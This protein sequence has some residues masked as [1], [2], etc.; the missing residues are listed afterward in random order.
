[1]MK[2]SEALILGEFVLPASRGRWLSRSKDGQ[3]CGA[4]AVGRACVAAGYYPKKFWGFY[5]ETGSNA[6]EGKFLSEFMSSTWPWS[7]AA[8]S[9]TPPSGIEELLPKCGA[10]K[11]LE[12]RH[13]NPLLRIIS[14]LYEY[15]FWS[16]QQLA[17]WVVTLE[18]Q[19]PV[20]QLQEVSNALQTIETR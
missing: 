20:P 17:A 7:A 9:V 1:M 5:C 6:I 14:D 4:C 16:M 8:D 2:L 11:I 3:L 18:P 15:Q 13:W 12:C 10:W 19:D